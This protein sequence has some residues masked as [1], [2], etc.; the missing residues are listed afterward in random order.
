MGKSIEELKF[1]PSQ[2][3]V[4]PVDVQKPKEP[5][6]PPFQSS[7]AKK[8]APNA[9]RS[10]GR[11]G[12]VVPVN[13]LADL[14]RQRFKGLDEAIA[15]IRSELALAHAS[16]QANLS[17]IAEVESGAS[18]LVTS[19]A[20]ESVRHRKEIQS[21][22]E[23]VSGEVRAL[24]ELSQT[25]QREAQVHSALAIDRAFS[26][27]Q[28]ASQ[29]IQERVHQLQDRVGILAM[30]A[31]ALEGI[32]PRLDRMQSEFSGFVAE[33][34]E[35]ME[36]SLTEIRNAQKTELQRVLSR[37]ESLEKS[38]FEQQTSMPKPEPI[39]LGEAIDFLN[40]MKSERERMGSL[41]TKLIEAQVHTIQS[42]EAQPSIPKS[43]RRSKKKASAA[44]AKIPEA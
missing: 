16:S 38:V 30:R 11:V 5:I 37:V 22:L 13:P 41:M 19:V 14:V 3:G 34:R 31:D 27:I 24:R 4:H 32:E 23:G 17:R 12:H 42:S 7:A 35:A 20:D 18:E 39:A 8:S 36:Q 25:V 21:A 1:D 43:K 2:I 9:P 40:Q 26:E 44:I 15:L 28:S 33:L 29:S 10:R 6:P